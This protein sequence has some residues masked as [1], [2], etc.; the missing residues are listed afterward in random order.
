MCTPAGRR[1]QSSTLK[2]VEARP[3]EDSVGK[4]LRGSRCVEGTGLRES[5]W[6]GGGVRQGRAR[7]HPPQLPCSSI[8]TEVCSFLDARVSKHDART[9][10]KT[11][12]FASVDLSNIK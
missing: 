3:R 5:G 8:S 6:E 12:S 11:T 10:Y 4:D 7:D 9:F 1:Q 2:T